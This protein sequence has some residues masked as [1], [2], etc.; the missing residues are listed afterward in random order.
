MT[1]HI[2]MID[3]N[4]AEAAYARLICEDWAKT[5]GHILLCHE[6]S[7]AEQFLFHAEDLPA[8]DILLLDIEMGRMNG[9]DLARRVREYDSRVQMVFITGYPDFIAEGYEVSAL[10]YLM[11]PVKREKL[12]GV[13]DRAASALGKQT[14]TVLLPVGKEF[15]CLPTDGI[16]YAESQGHYMIVYTQ[17][18]ELKCRMTASELLALLGDGFARCHR[19]VIVGLHRVGRVTKT[20]VFLTDGT[21]LP[22][23][24]GLYDALN[25]ALIVT[26]REM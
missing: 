6:F 14:Q 3:D 8:F 22:L 4:P 11:K 21:E 12:F 15:L 10:H 13:L 7:S 19:S 1:Y 2:A 24:K 9:V 20:A 18:G 23:G 26:L 16:R 17:G 5:A 25:R